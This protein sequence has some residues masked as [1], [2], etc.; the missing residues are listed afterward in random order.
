MRNVPG[1]RSIVITTS[2]PERQPQRVLATA[3]RVLPADIAKTVAYAFLSARPRP[4]DVMITHGLECPFGKLLREINIMPHPPSRTGRQIHALLNPHFNKFVSIHS[5]L[6]PD[7]LIITQSDGQDNSFQTVA[8]NCAVMISHDNSSRSQSCLFA[9]GAPES[10]PFE[11]NLEDMGDNLIIL[12][13]TDSTKLGEPNGASLIDATPTNG[14]PR[15]RG[16]NRGRKR[17][18]SAT[19]NPAG[20]VS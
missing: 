1:R 6:G 8:F 3:R 18:L 11:I 13:A 19:P 17:A 5:M 15:H 9:S 12:H 4:G 14:R 2:I 7:D 16:G 20:D 10:I